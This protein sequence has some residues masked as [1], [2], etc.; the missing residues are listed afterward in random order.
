M[1]GDLCSC[2]LEISNQVISFLFLLESSEHHLGARDVLL[3]VLQ[4]H[5]QGVLAPGDA[6]VL[7]GLG[8]G[9]ASGLTSLAA[10]QSPEVRACVK[11]KI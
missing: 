6:L 9:E 7:V 1:V 10:N 3:G 8:V 4:V 11:L 2:S 5:I